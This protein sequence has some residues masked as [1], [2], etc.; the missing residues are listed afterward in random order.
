MSGQGDPI[1]LATAFARTQAAINNTRAPRLFDFTCSRML[2]S[3]GDLP[4]G[5]AEEQIRQVTQIRTLVAETCVEEYLKAS[6]A[7]LEDAAPL[8]LAALI[9]RLGYW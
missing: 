4:P 5:L 7:R 9:Y 3:A 6:Q 8:Q 1:A 2:M